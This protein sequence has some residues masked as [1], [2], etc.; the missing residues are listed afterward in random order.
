M[1]TL[2]PGELLRAMFDAAVRAAL[3][4]AVV[5]AHLPQPPAGRTVVVGAG[6]ASAAMAGALE[7]HWPGSLEGLVV[8]RYGHG[9]PCR[10]IEIVEAAH[11][12]PD[13]AGQRAAEQILAMV[14]GLGED[15]LIIALISGGGSSLLSL[16]APGL[17][18]E[19]KQAVNRALLR[20]GAPIDAMNCVRKHLS[21]I[22]GGRLAAAAYPA[23]IVT[24]VISDVPADDP[25]VIASGP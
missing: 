2:P 15:D 6:K 5:P 11:P 19:D 22:K 14:Q 20:S 7:D 13:E 24:L 18:L 4:A 21:A 25:S 12:V 8:T 23:E 16:P 10:R 1:S 3:P 9:V 17:T